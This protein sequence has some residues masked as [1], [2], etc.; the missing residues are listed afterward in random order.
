MYVCVSDAAFAET[1]T[2]SFAKFKEGKNNIKRTEYK[3]GGWFEV[4]DREYGPL[5]ALNFPTRQTINLNMLLSISLLAP[6][7]LRSY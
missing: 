2:I 3:P 4:F 5:A 1:A 6:A 7:H